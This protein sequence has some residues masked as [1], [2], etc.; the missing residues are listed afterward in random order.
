[1][2]TWNCKKGIT[3]GALRDLAFLRRSFIDLPVVY[4]RT[5]CVSMDE[6]EDWV[7]V[8]RNSEEERYFQTPTKDIHV[9]P[10]VWN[11]SSR[12]T[13][14]WC[15]VVGGRKGDVSDLN[16]LEQLKIIDE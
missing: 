8:I 6:W 13:F 12:V 9:I 2:I 1:M 14:S 10:V 5:S 7:N 4:D 15:I 11:D 16:E 3:R